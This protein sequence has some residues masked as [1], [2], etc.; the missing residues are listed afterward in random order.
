MLA[1]VK[2][3]KKWCIYI[4]PFR[5]EDAQ[6]RFTMISLPPADRKHIYQA[7]NVC[8]Y[9]FYRPRKDGKLSEL[10]FS[11]KEGRLNIQPSTRPGIEPGTSGLGGR[12]LYPSANPSACNKYGRARKLAG[13]YSHQPFAILLVLFHR[14][15]GLTSREYM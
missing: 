4:A 7:V 3:K 13:L 6:R 15:I 10:N 9:S 1:L 2:S 5:Y 14:Q 8:W 12:D 11:G